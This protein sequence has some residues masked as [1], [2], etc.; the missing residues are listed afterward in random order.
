MKKTMLLAALL[1]CVLSACAV[2]PAAPKEPGAPD[3]D[4]TVMN[5]TMVYGEVYNMM[6]NPEDYMGKTVKARGPYYA[7]FYEETGQVYHF[8]LIED[9]AACCQQGLE[10]IWDGHAYPDSFPPDNTNVEV[11]GVFG[12]YEELGEVYYYLA[13]GSMTVL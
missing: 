7:S 5:A 8:V 11:T 1:C 6:T 2:P 12:Q 13:V 3:V 10:F 9:A 4:L